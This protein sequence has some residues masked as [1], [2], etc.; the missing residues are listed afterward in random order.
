MKLIKKLFGN[1]SN[2]DVVF[3]RRGELGR[4]G[5]VGP[6]E[7]GWLCGTGSL[8]VRTIANRIKSEYLALIFTGTHASEWLTTESVGSTMDNLNTEMLGHFKVQVPPLDEQQAII[9]SLKQD[10]ARTAEL[11]ETLQRSIAILKERRSAL[12]TPA[13]TGQLSSHN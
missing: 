8:R 2:G 12:I 7:V 6:T 4:C 9:F 11:E 5:I 13:V 3:A 10:R 1:K